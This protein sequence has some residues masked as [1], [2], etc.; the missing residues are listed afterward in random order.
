MDEHA[1]RKAQQRYRKAGLVYDDAE[2]NIEVWA[3][4]WTEI[5]ANARARLQ[6]INASL[7]YE[8]NRVSA[9]EFLLKAHA[10]F[11]PDVENDETETSEDD[12]VRET[13]PDSGG[14]HDS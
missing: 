3:F 11:I 14:T 5:I 12:G 1:R 4:E 2:L 10:R 9:R 6:F 13:V 7:S 8:A